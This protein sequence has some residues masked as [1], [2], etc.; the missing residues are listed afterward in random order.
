MADHEY[1]GV[2]IVKLIPWSSEVQYSTVQLSFDVQFAGLLK[3]KQNP[4][5]R[6]LIDLEMHLKQVLGAKYKNRTMK[7]HC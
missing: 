5:D 2:G 7:R 1:F 6:I 3:R 4:M